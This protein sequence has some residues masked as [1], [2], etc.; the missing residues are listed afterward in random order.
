MRNPIESTH[1]KADGRLRILDLFL[2]SWC[3]A[4]GKLHINHNYINSSTPW[5][6]TPEFP[7]LQVELQMCEELQ[8]YDEGL[9]RLCVE[10]FF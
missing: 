9:H 10:L 7:G 4:L 5:F 3:T 6:V 8:I 2:L 1:K